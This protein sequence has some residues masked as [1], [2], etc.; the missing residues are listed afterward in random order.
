M[1]IRKL[2]AGEARVLTNVIKERFRGLAAS[3]QKFH[4]RQGW[5]A[6]GYATFTEWWAT[7]LGETPFKDDIITWAIGKMIDEA[8]KSKRGHLL[9]SSREKIA[10][11][12]GKT[13][14]TLRTMVT[15]KNNPNSRKNGI[16]YTRTGQELVSLSCFIP[17]EWRSE[18]IT[19]ASRD[20]TT[21]S[22][23]IRTAIHK[24]VQECYGIKLVND[25]TTSREV[26]DAD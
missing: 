21:M 6:L 9:P 3:L 20:R 14:A 5:T 17:N 12:T 25:G 8:P 18:F 2:S 15:Q 16:I 13:Y 24:G 4:S 1:T 23:I 26:K 22:H 11:A 10:S 7:E 19:L